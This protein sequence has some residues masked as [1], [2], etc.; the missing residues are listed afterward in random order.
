MVSRPG[1]PVSPSV[2]LAE[3]VPSQDAQ[4]V[5]PGPPA[6]S[7]APVHPRRVPWAWLRAQSCSSLGGMGFSRA[8]GGFGVCLFSFIF[9]PPSQLCPVSHPLP[10]P[11]CWSQR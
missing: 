1:L 5:L 11:C 2:L 4:E 8:E 10:P 3:P 6:V 9:P 7:I